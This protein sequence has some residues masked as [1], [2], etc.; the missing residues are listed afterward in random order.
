MLTHLYILFVNNF[1]LITSRF[2]RVSK[3]IFI[4]NYLIKKYKIEYAMQPNIV[5]KNQTIKEIL[6]YLIIFKN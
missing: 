3:T 2:V 1:L 6:F 5:D 4:Y